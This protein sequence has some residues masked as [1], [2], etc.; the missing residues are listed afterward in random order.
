MV[1]PLSLERTYLDS[2]NLLCGELL[3]SGIS[4][5]VYECTIDPSLVVKVESSESRRFAN[6]FENAF[7]VDYQYMPKVAAWLAPC[8]KLSPDGRVLLQ[9]RCQPLPHDYVLPEKLPAFLTDHKRGNFGL[10]QGRLVCVDYAM[11]TLN[12][13]MVLRKAY[14]TS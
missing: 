7:W 1:V 14:F 12:P 10:Y 3:G 11:T 8:V 4:R 9:K 2:F 13:S 6:V 5:Y